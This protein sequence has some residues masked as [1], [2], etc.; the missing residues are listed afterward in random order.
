MTELFSVYRFK[1]NGS[2]P[3]L[4]KSGLTLDQARAWCN[5]PET[6]SKTAKQPRGC[7]GKESTIERWHTTQRHWFDGYRMEQE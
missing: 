6:S 3:K 4:Q 5:D 2:K 1:E 7:G